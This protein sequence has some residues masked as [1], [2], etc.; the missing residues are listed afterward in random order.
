MPN[1]VYF[2]AN[3]T[4]VVWTDTTGDLAMTLANLANDAVRIGA[5]KDFGAATDRSEW[6]EWRLIIGGLVSTATIGET[7][8]LYF[9]TDSED[10]DGEDGNV[11]TGDALGATGMLPNLKFA[12]S[13]VTRSGTITD[14]NAASGIIRLVG[15]YISPVVHNQNSTNLQNTSNI[16]KVILTPIPPEIQ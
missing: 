10:Q 6:Y 9:A 1:L 14:D 5:V 3:Q 12:G 4:P 16:H 15:R 8:D 13:A 11:G 7:A 2:A